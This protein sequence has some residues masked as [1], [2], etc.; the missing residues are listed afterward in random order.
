VAA[1][2]VELSFDL[3]ICSLD[4][5]TA[6]MNNVALLNSVNLRRAAASW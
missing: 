2:K 4:I 6:V 5:S 1:V 3:R